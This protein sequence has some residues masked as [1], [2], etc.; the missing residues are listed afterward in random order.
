MAQERDYYEVLGV[1]RDADNDAIK[2]AFRRLA[3][4]YHPDRNTSEHEK[5]AAE[6]KFKEAK[7]ACEVLMDPKKRQIYDQMGHAGIDQMAGAGGFGGG[8]GGFS[9]EDIFSGFEDIFGDI[10][11]ARRGGS[12]RQQAYAGADL[13]YDLSLTLEEAVAGKTARLEVFTLVSCETCDGSGA[14]PGSKPITCQKCGGHGEIRLQQGFLAIQQ[15]CPTCHGA[16][17]VIADPCQQCH[18]QGRH[19]ASKKLDVKIPGGI[20]DGDRIRLAN[21]GEAGINGG[22]PGDLYVY[23]HVKKHPIFERQ[24]DDLHCQIPISFVT[25]AVGG[26]VEVPTLDGKVKLKIPAETQSDKLF[27]LRGK[28]VKSVRGRGTGDMLCRVVVE[29]LVKLSKQQKSLLKEFDQV[30]QNDTIDHSPQS[31]N[32]FDRVKDFFES[33]G[34]NS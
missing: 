20:D 13:R 33:I 7:K 1:A 6:K 32:F 11:G 26:S 21:E 15:T 16:G 2:K 10:F 5:T 31:K 23:T 34:K 17:T 27:R 24:K 28:G 8:G 29:T 12:H 25:A 22:P 3:M 19:K 4:K 9:G 14:K 30:L 18:G